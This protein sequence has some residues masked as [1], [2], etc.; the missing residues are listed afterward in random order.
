M[1]GRGIPK[2]HYGMAVEGIDQGLDRDHKEGRSFGDRCRL[3]PES[4]TLEVVVGYCQ[5][6]HWA[7]GAQMVECDGD[8]G[9]NY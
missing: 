6:P 5:Y 7:E 3:A 2:D 8:Q 4:Q 1:E 9:R